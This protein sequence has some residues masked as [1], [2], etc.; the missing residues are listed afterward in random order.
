LIDNA[1]DVYIEAG[2]TVGFG[3]DPTERRLFYAYTEGQNQIHK[4]IGIPVGP[5]GTNHTFLIIANA[6]RQEWVLVVDNQRID[7][8]P[9][10]GAGHADELQV[11]G[12]IG[13]YTNQLSPNAS[14]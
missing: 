14:I 1:N 4:R 12:E 8:W 6:N 13:N 5:A 2:Y 10:V 9:F 3:I 7:S 11:G